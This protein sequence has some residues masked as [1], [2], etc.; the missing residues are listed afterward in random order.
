MTARRSAWLVSPRFDAAVFVA[1]ALLS[2]LV[3]A[4]S[5]ALADSIS[6]NTVKGNRIK[7]K[8]FC[9][10]PAEERLPDKNIFRVPDYS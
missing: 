10:E 1:P 7:I 6:V 5:S 3:A 2:L 8:V 9:P 4:F